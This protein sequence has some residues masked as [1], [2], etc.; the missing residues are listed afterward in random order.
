MQ[1]ESDAKPKKKR[2]KKVQDIKLLIDLLLDKLC[3]W[4]S[5][6]QDEDVSYLAKGSK[7]G[8]TLDANS[9]KSASGDRLQNFCIEVIV[10]LY[11][12]L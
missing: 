11:V 5:V 1:L 10:P 3:I 4:Q 12:A 9:S 6:E 8:D 7:F 2:K